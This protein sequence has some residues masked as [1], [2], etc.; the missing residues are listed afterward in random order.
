LDGGFLIALEAQ[1]FIIGV[2]IVYSLN[3][4]NRKLITSIVFLAMVGSML[5]TFVVAFIHKTNMTL[6]PTDNALVSSAR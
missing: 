4:F 1:F 2:A 5:Y 6:I 3:R